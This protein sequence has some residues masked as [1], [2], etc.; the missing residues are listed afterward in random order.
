MTKNKNSGRIGHDGK[1]RFYNPSKH[2]WQTQRELEEEQRAEKIANS[3]VTLAAVILGG[4]GFLWML[5]MT[6]GG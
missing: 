6:F 1:T 5:I 4:G 3:M 2:A